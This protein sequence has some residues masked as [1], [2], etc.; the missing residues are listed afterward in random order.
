MQ[1]DTLRLWLAMKINQRLYMELC[2]EVKEYG[3]YSLFP[4]SVGFLL[5]NEWVNGTWILLFC[6]SMAGFLLGEISSLLVL[7][8]WIR[9]G[10]WWWPGATQPSG[11]HKNAVWVDTL[12]FLPCFLF[13]IKCNLKLQHT[14]EDVSFLPFLGTAASNNRNE[15]NKTFS[16]TNSSVVKTK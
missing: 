1:Y 11:V 3:L 12:M 10:A 8:P 16:L 6:V 9:R 14:E 4:I 15:Q 7:S 5:G 2:C 13:K